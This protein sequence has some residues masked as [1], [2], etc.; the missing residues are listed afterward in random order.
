MLNYKVPWTH[1][2]GTAEQPLLMGHTHTNTKHARTTTEL[3]A[4]TTE[5]EIEMATT[6]P[7]MAATEPEETNATTERET[8]T[9][10]RTGNGKRQSPPRRLHCL[11]L[12]PSGSRAVPHTSRRNLRPTLSPERN[13]RVYGG[14][15]VSFDIARRC[16]CDRLLR[17]QLL[18]LWRS[19]RCGTFSWPTVFA[20]L[21]MFIR[22]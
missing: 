13:P 16:C 6:E 11:S 21:M 12:W 20:T 10:P 19:Q 9:N 8:A 2:A 14:I 17:L 4:T 22:Q 7:E 5:R 1:V 3:E 15:R 18:Q